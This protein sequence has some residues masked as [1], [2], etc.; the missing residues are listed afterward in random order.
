LQA[1]L[2]FG[3][4]AESEKVNG[5]VDESSSAITQLRELASRIITRRTMF[6]DVQFTH[7]P[8]AIAIACAV[9]AAQE[10][11]RD[12]RHSAGEL[13]PASVKE[14][15]FEGVNEETQSV[16]TA[17][18]AQVRQMSEGGAG[19]AVVQRLE[20]QRKELR[21]PWTD[22]VTDEYRRRNAERESKL[23]EDRR[24]QAVISQEK[25]RKETAMLMGFPEP[26]SVDRGDAME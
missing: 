19:D 8:A 9:S 23:E 4:A 5:N 14:I 2:V 12:S 15:C 1:K 22:P 21:D 6:T 26:E 25:R 20:A 3:A 16:I 18:I 11:Q 10:L 17:L 13:D 7:S 24:K